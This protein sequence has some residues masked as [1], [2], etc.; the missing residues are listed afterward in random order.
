MKHFPTN[1]RSPKYR[2][3]V[4]NR[5]LNTNL[6]ASDVICD[7]RILR[8]NT[9]SSPKYSTVLLHQSPA[10]NTRSRSSITSFV[11]VG[12]EEHHWPRLKPTSQKATHMG[13]QPSVIRR[14]NKD[15]KMNK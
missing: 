5:K 12:S 9:S 11:P 10:S 3:T 4:S 6:S 7:R 14:R 8:S 15:D 1:E 13:Q 2:K